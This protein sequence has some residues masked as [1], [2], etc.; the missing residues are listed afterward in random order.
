MELARSAPAGGL[1]RRARQRRDGRALS[2]IAA[3]EARA[4]ARRSPLASLARLAV[5]LGLGVLT[6]VFGVTTVGIDGSSMEPT[7]HD[8]ERAL[9]PRYET[10][11]R[12]E[13][14]SGW[15]A[16]DVVY[17]R[18]PGATPQGWVDRITGGPFLIKR[19]AAV[20]GQTVWL[21]QGRLVVDGATVAEPY[22]E[23]A[24]RAPIGA[25]PRLVPPDHVFVLGDNR[26]P[27]ASR[28]SRVFG[29]VPLAQV[30]G[31]AAWVVWPPVRQD[32]D[33]GWRWN[34]RRL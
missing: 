8:G 32:A 26:A 20:G 17:F 9:V 29:P 11:W 16:G 19:V 30:A 13:R 10:W 24:P 27:L 31:R 5:V 2:E 28:D 34:V 1:R 3:H 25:T 4:S 6:A 12:R 18:P 15:D 33:G 7:L 23:G 21:E 22:L 14:G